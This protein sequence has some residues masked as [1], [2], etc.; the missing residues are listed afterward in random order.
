M[1]IVIRFFFLA[2][3]LISATHLLVA[4]T[5]RPIDVAVDSTRTYPDP[6]EFVAV[7][8]EPKFD[9]EELYRNLKYPEIARKNNI[10]G[11]VVM[12]VLIDE[13]GN[14]V[15]YMILQTVDQILNEAAKRAVLAT[16]FSPARLQ[17]KPIAT[18]IAIP[19]SFRMH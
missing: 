17:G 2:F 12:Q 5:P 8:V 11:L 1:K 10:E 7:D 9:S 18:W 6:D 14:V 3:L 16:A 15:K 19:V 4:Q 13:E